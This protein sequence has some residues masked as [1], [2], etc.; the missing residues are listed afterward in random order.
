[1]IKL[2]RLSEMKYTSGTI[3]FSI[4]ISNRDTKGFMF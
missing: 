2:D 4:K 1:M 3:R